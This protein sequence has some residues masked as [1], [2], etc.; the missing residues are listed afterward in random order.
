MG[1]DINGKE[2]GTG[3][4]QRK[5]GRYIARFVQKA[6]KRVEKSFGRLNEAKSWLSK[7]RYLDEITDTCNMTVEM[8]F[9]NWITSYKEGI[10][11]QNTIKNYKNRYNINIKNAIGNMQLNEVKQIHCQKILNKMSDSGRYSQGTIELCKTTLHAL[12][13]DA[14]ESNYLLKNPAEGLKMRRLTLE[15][16]E[17]NERRVLSREEQKT[18]LKYAEGTYY[19]NAYCF[20]LETGLR[21]GEI[22]ALSDEDIDFEAKCLH[23]R[24][25][26]LYDKNKGG[27]YIGLP[28]SR[29]SIRIVP[30]TD[31]AVAALERQKT[32]MAKAK[33]KSTNWNSDWD[34]L[35]FRS[36]NGNPVGASTYRGMIARIVA[37][38]NLDRQIKSKEE[39]SEYVEFEAMGMHTLRHSFA[40]RAIEN[41]VNPKSLQKILG[42]STLSITMD[43][44]VHVLD[45]QI[46]LEMNKMNCAV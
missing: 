43:L 31:A 26:L 16:M 3:L 10:V 36:N 9:E 22:G 45:D 37:N 18:F 11:A 21:V 5:D 39:G 7:Q 38:I 14:V 12:F 25:T 29:H 34:K 44:Y 15:E 27:F 1:K 4:A 20:A 13:K 35:I 24:H 8:W 6:G 32:L 19:Y 17:D 42:H 33:A 28:K 30:L 2:L 40:T 41:G 23:V 46:F